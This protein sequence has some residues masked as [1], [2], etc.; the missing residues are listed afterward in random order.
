[1][2]TQLQNIRKARGFRSARD[3]ANHIGI[4]PSTYTDY[5][6]GRRVFSLEKAWEFADVLDCTLDELAGRD[7]PRPAF[8]DKDQEALNGYY[9]S[10][11]KEGRG[12]LVDAARLMSGSPDTRIEKDG[13][14][15]TDVQTAM[16]A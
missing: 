14:K 8:T 16:G 9:E 2:K 10:M 6:Q 13:S 5:E 4:K 3:F 1:M 11:N 15:H 7:F 12:A